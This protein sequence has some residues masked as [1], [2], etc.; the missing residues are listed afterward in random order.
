MK[1]PTAQEWTLSVKTFSAAML[2]LGIGLAAGLDRPYWAMAT[3]YVASQP[4][5]GTTRSKAVFRLSGTLLGAAAAVVLV[6]NFAGSPEILS[7]ALAAWTAACLALSL[8]D[9]TPRS[10]VFMLASYTAAIIG[11]PSVGAPDAIWDTAVARSE[12]IGLGIVCASLV[13]SLVFPRHVGPVVA[14]RTEAWLR[15]GRL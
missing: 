8:L 11:F 13:A 14:Q 3:V 2:A 9:R 15:D 12:E 5:S 4:L 1:L 10:Y 6:P 7:L